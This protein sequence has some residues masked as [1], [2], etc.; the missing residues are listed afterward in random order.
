MQAEGSAPAADWS[1]WEHDRKAPASQDGSGLAHDFADDFAL[2]AQLG[3]T[4]IRLTL[5][6]ARLEPEPGRIDRA[7][8]DRYHDIVR[9]ARA[10]GLAPWLTLHA[11]SLPGWF[12]ED[13]RG[14]RDQRSRERFWLPHVDRCAEHFGTLA[15][16]WI[17]V[18]DPIGWALRG[19]HL[20]NRPP[21]RRD[22]QLF[23]DAVEGALEADHAAAQLLARGHATTMAV[24]GVPT[25]FAAGEAPTSD[26]TQNHV[27][28]W[29]AFLFDIWA[30]V[31]DSGELAIPDVGI[32]IRP[33]WVD[34]FDFIGLNFDH[35]IGVTETGGLAPYPASGRRSDTGFVPLPEELGVLLERMTDR[36]PNRQFMISANGV[37]TTDDEWRE[38]LLRDTVSVLESLKAGGLPL[39]GYFHD[40]GIDGYELRAGFETQ[41]GLIDRDRN[42]KGSGH[43]LAS[44]LAPT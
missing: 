1:A 10:A 6:W 21:G 2:L 41:R 7:A 4:D 20:G 40:T 44:L 34:D 22:P 25:I 3:L 24:R 31:L 42:I 14:F 35:P 16:G 23:R 37:S 29:A 32:R 17:A 43:Y 36:L 12:N 11:T 18:E 15:E 9:A 5:E 27:K 19:Y 38:E 28:W 33:E 30:D 26:D 13:E 39:A 8:F